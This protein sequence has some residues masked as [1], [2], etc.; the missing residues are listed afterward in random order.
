VAFRVGAEWRYAPNMRARFGYVFDPTPINDTY[1]TPAIPG[2]D[3]HLFSVGY[4][5]D[6]SDRATIDLAY[7]FVYFKKRN[8]TASTGLSASVNGTYKATAHIVS[9][10]LSW[11]F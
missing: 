9:A 8:Q 7:V 11:K 10:S 4:G 5:Y 6:F 1:F 3:R 2:N